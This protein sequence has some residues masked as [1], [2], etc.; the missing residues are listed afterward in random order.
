MIEESRLRS[1][2]H[3]R[4]AVSDVGLLGNDMEARWLAA[5]LRQAL[6]RAGWRP[7][8]RPGPGAA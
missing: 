3:A 5:Q 8:A 7:A 4:M 1:L 6:K 2:Y